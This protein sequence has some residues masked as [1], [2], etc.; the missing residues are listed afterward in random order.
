MERGRSQL[1]QVDEKLACTRCFK[2]G[3]L[4]H[5]AKDCPQNKELATSSDTFFSGMVCNDSC[6]GRPGND[7]CADHSRKKSCAGVPS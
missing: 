5:F 7:F 4:G 3:E 2:C 1:T 6:I